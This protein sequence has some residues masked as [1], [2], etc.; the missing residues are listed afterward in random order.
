MNEG[1][2]FR[3]SG[4]LRFYSTQPTQLCGGGKHRRSGENTEKTCFEGMEGGK[5]S[6]ALKTEYWFISQRCSQ[7]DFGQDC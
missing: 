5:L 3:S 6:V 1:K 2:K 4:A 7:G